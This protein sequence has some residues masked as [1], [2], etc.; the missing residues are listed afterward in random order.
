MK[1]IKLFEQ[2]INEKYSSSD[3]KKLKKFAEKVI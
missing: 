2:F 3:I 1:H